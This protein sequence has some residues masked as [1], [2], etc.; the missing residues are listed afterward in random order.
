MLKAAK[1]NYLVDHI[2]TYLDEPAIPST[3]IQAVG[4]Y[5]K[6]WYTSSSAWKSVARMAMDYCSAPASSVD[7]EQ[8]FSVGR[9]QINFM[10]Q[11]MSSFTFHAKMAMGSWSNTPLFPG[12]KA[13]AEMIGESESDEEDGS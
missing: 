12:V 8:A 5:M 13:V 6:W 7:A 3:D 11:N 1:T 4:G 9:Q 10:Q 2:L